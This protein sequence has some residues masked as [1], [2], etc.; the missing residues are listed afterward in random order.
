MPSRAPTIR[1]V[2]RHSGVGVGTVSRVLN[3]S[4]RVRPDKRARVLEAIAELGFV[5]NPTAHSLSTGRS[6]AI[7][8]IAPF[9]TSP[10]SA[11]RLRGV[12]TGVAEHGYR[13]LLVDVETPEQRASA[14][15][16]LAGRHAVEGVIVVSIEPTDGE[17][18]ALAR[19]H[20]PMVLVDAAH[21]SLPHVAIDDRLGGELATGHLLGKGHTRI[22]FVGD[23]LPAPFGLSSSELR[24][25]G[26][27]AALERAGL[28]AR[29]E[30][31]RLG[32]HDRDEARDLAAP[33]FALEQPPTAVFAA[34]DIQ[35]VGVIEAAMAAG[36][37]V[38]EDAAVIGFDDIELAAVVGLT[39]VRQPLRASGRRGAELLL[40]AIEGTPPPPGELEPLTVVERRTT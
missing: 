35:A 15:A 25:S 27:R 17:V 39:T 14:F 26:H 34:S 16:D 5:R 6:H 37:R 2:A 29:P 28:K 33:L 32:G 8:V 12:S 7:G 13:L 22:A 38:P 19:E 31:V 24:L 11:E 23:R 4:P 40:A 9:F 1:D 30:Y 3:D 21:P 10:S 36:L 18:A 20:R